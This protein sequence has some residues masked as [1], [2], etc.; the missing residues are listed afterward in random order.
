MS[1]TS[2]STA[3][4]SLATA[5]MSQPASKMN[6]SRAVC[7]SGSA[8]DHVRGKTRFAFELGEKSLKNIDRPVRLYAVRQS[9]ATASTFFDTGA[10]DPLALPDKPSVAVLPHVDEFGGIGLC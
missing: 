4:I 7:L 5:L 3:T 9:A 8:F 1:V 2:S 6:T 10:T